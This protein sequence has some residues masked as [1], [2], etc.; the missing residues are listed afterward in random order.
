M[1]KYIFTSCLFFA[2]IFSSCE[3][4]KLPTDVVVDENYWKTEQDFVLA[5]NGLYP[6]L[7]SYTTRDEYS[8]I[9]YGGTPNDISSGTYLP[10]NDFGPWNQAYANI[11]SAN[12][13][14]TFAQKNPNEIDES[15]TK[16]YEGEAKFFRALQYYNLLRS[17]GGVPIIETLLDVDS[18]ELYAPRNTREEVVDFILKDLDSAIEALP[19]PSKLNPTEIG[20]FTKSAAYTL[21]SRVALYEGT[22]QKN[23][24]HGEYKSYLEEA[25]AAALAVIKS[26]EH[27]LYTDASKDPVLN[28]QNCFTYEGEGSKE[29]ILANRY[30]KPW[31][32][33]K[34][35][36]N[37]LRGNRCQPTR[38]IVD[39][40]LC[41]DGLPIQN[42]K[43]FQGYKAP[44]SEYQNRDP[45]MKASLYVP[46]E[47]ITWSGTPY[48]PRFDQG[49][50]MTGY[51]WKKMTVIADAVALEGDLDPI[52]I[53]YAET[54]LN[55]A[56]A[57]FELGEQI[58]DADLDISINVLRKRV[59]MPKLTNAFA[60]QNGLNMRN[61]IRRER[62]VEL[63]NEGFRYDDL[64][65]WGEAE[66]VL[67]KALVGIPDLR[68]FY[69]FVPK[70]VW[71]QVKDGFVELQPASERVFEKQHYLWPIPLVQ[72]ALNG[73]LKQNPGW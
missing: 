49:T 53:R 13:I 67:P 41:S 6:K 47:D 44:E 22:R 18:K 12:K 66:K 24:E 29:T 70:N 61:E 60:S 30:Q 55:Y 65:R 37:V 54:L 62:L 58:S 14:I 8:D 27:V 32:K 50:S 73:N 71:A 21:K 36:Q 4:E 57:S 68:E 31:R 15:I 51:T 3:L 16:R 56:E 26:K 9:C 42:S 72:I 1:K 69:K 20:R 34:N 23:V 35:S 46:F 2:T 40:F 28:F 39:A 59:S 43:L 11:A 7:P 17:Y 5:C 10:T 63:A 38:A 19:W 48:E 45:R 52:I 33:H 25:K 64:M